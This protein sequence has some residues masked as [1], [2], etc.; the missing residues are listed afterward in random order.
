MISVYHALLAVVTAEYIVQSEWLSSTSCS[1]PPS[2]IY[3]F[4]V[5][6]LSVSEKPENETWAPM[7]ELSIK[8]YAYGLCGN[9][10]IE[11]IG[12]CCF[13]SLQQSQSGG[14]LSGIS[15]AQ[16]QPTVMYS[17]P[18][19]AGGQQYCSITPQNGTTVFGYEDALIH[20]SGTCTDKMICYPNGKF[21][22]YSDSACSKLLASV[23]L[24]L[25]PVKV[26]GITDAVGKFITTPKGF[27]STQWIAAVPGSRLTPNTSSFYDIIQHILYGLTIL[28]FLSSIISLYRIKKQG[29]MNFMLGLQIV[30]LIYVAFSMCYYYISF[31]E[32][33]QSHLVNEFVKSF[34]NLASFAT[35]LHT[36]RLL[37]QVWKI[38]S[39]SIQ[40]YLLFFVLF[41]LHF[42][43]AGSNYFAFCWYEGATVCVSQDLLGA[44]YAGNA[45]WIAFMF[46]WD[47][48]PVIV[49]V[50]RI[51]VTHQPALVFSQVMV[52]LITIDYKFSML[53][54]S[55]VLI[56]VFYFIS[57]A[58]QTYGDMLGNDRGYLAC[59]AFQIFCL[60]LHTTLNINLLNRMMSISKKLSQ[61]NDTNSKS[62]GLD[63][64]QIN[65]DIEQV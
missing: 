52:K 8:D 28:I 61:Y 56:V 24:S 45:F 65:Y 47:T 51:I 26:K 4:Q 42:G 29:F 54:F 20:A 37:L 48:I 38:K 62:A 2:S 27:G 7:Y 25:D 16:I 19:S 50:W 17:L 22:V 34:L 21:E 12:Y 32:S 3:S 33:F 18:S 46:I 49:A 60:C 5:A 15:I 64:S 31:Q 59:T 55:Q 58:I 1:G 23:N 40:S 35:V 57:I 53:L 63:S 39:N 41:V 6:D 36:A 14:Y 11:L 44:W 10:P 43:L 30:W 9:L 13:N